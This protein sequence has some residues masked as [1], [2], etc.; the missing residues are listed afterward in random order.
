KFNVPN[1]IPTMNQGDAASILNTGYQGWN[2]LASYFARVNYAFN[3]R[4]LLTATIRRDGSSRFGSEKL[5]GWF[6]SAS[7]GWKLNQEDFLS[8]VDAISNLKLRAGW[9]MTGNENI[10][11]YAFG[12]SLVTETSAFG[13]AVRN[14]QYSNPL[15]QW[16]AT[17]QY[18]V[19]MDL[20]LLDDRITMSVDAYLKDTDNLLLRMV[21]PA[22]FGSQVAGPWANVGRMEN[23]GIEV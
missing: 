8:Q 1:D 23:K 22:T 21:L 17:T 4:Y 20:G 10:G 19:G 5:W 2:S 7:L 13:S 18:N 11:N 3:D 6:P 9:G 14:A 12:S 16:E 15:V